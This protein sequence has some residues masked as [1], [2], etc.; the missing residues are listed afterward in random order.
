MSYKYPPD[1][2]KIKE[3]TITNPTAGSDFIIPVPAYQVWR[4]HNIV[5]LLTTSAVV[6][7]RY[8]LFIIDDGANMVYD[9]FL[10]TIAAG[11]SIQLNIGEFPLSMWTVGLT[12]IVPLPTPS[13]IAEG[14]RI[15]SSTVNLDAGDT[16]TNIKLWISEWLNP[17]A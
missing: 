5:A 14:W 13:P 1:F 8:P 17:H 11:Q 7:T 10:G 2:G 16:W 15:R 9:M 4:I 3:V 12:G 6:N